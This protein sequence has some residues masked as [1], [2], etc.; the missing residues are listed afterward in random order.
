[1]NIFTIEAKIQVN[2]TVEMSIHSMR[3][4]YIYEMKNAVNSIKVIKLNQIM[5]NQ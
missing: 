4:Y 5:A 1:M 2:N 3:L